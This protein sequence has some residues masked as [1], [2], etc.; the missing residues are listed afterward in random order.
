MP[1]CSTLIFTHF[2]E[3]NFELVAKCVE[4]YAKADG[5]I[6]QHIAAIASPIVKRLMRIIS[7]YC[8]GFFTDYITLVLFDSYR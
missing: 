5:E 6:A 1:V 2:P 8:F 7:F 3:A 4:E